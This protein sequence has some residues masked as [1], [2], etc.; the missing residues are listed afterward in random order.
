M[1]ESVFFIARYVIRHWK[2]IILSGCLGLSHS[3]LT[4]AA[5]ALLAPILELVI[6]SGISGGRGLTAGQSVR[7][8]LDLNTLGR[9]LLAPI[10]QALGASGSTLLW[11]LGGLY[12]LLFVV[13]NVID[14]GNQMLVS[15][16]RLRVTRDTQVG[17][18]RHL[19]GLSMAFFNWR[20]TGELLSRVHNDVAAACSPI[21][22]VLHVVVSQPVLLA[23]YATA[24]MY[25]NATLALVAFGVAVA[26]MGIARSTGRRVQRKML[27]KWDSF[28]DLT[29]IIQETFLSNRVVKAFSAE[30]FHVGHFAGEVRAFERSE[31]KSIAIAYAGR[32]LRAIANAL[33]VVVLVATGSALLLR[34]EMTTSGLV[35]FLVVSQ[36]MVKP[37]ASLGEAIEQIGFVA[38]AA[39][40]V[41]DL[42]RV[43]PQVRDG[44]WVAEGLR[45][46]LKLQ[47]V[48]FS[49]GDDP[50]LEG[51]DLEIRRGEM[52]G[53]VGHSGSGK[54][55]LA[56]LLL[57]FYD[58]TRGVIELDGVD[59]REFTQAS[60]RKL[61]GV[62]P[63]E[64]LL[65]NDTVE[66]NIAYG[67]PGISHEQIVEAAKVANAHD[68]ILQL[69]QGYNTY[70][71]DRGIRLSGGERQRIAI[72]RAVVTHPPILVFDEAT[73]ALDSESEEVVQKAI[74]QV[75]K[76]FSAI[77]IAHRLSTIQNADRIVV[78]EKGRIME[79]GT[80]AELLGNGG[81][82]CRLY[83]LQFKSE[84]RA[85]NGLPGPH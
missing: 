46:G 40:R 23:V 3:L 21:E 71:G 4:A 63:Q 80:H 81:P 12:I 17:L 28:A 68:F 10:A 42:L 31:L 67:R 57:R 77:I 19:L 56:D 24:L 59:I 29:S 6:G 70:V 74:E 7:S 75:S 20:R 72:A 5:S 76:G 50:L 27:A 26:Q 48:C 9:E 22:R 47:G 64:T 51:L 61:F 79:V 38:G 11:L 13:A 14:Y 49:Y 39:Q 52:L 60:Y 8:G 34:G 53:I 69:A 33:A 85:E 54:S 18:F 37:V 43:Q 16:I 78:L 2:L 25:T 32:P 1:P 35:L 82:Y 73:S 84:G 55:T 44:Q 36:L 58:P 83:Q 66:N 65:F 45:H 41:A 15:W 30:G 62:V